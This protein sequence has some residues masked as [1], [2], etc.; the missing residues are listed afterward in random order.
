MKKTLVLR[1][2]KEN[3][4]KCSLL[5]LESDPNFL[6]FTYPK[7]IP[8]GLKSTILL[9]IDAPLLTPED[10]KFDLFLIDGTWRYAATMQEQVLKKNPKLI[11]RTLPPIHTAYPRKQ[12]LCSDPERGLASIEALYLAHKLTN[13]PYEHLLDRYYWKEQFLRNCDAY[14]KEHK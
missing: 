13:R 10:A 4:K 6:F 5:G 12:T 8:E 7:Q 9:T 3:L 2:C 1:H 11:L 14:F